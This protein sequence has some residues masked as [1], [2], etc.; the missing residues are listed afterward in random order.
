MR[1]ALYQPDMPPNVGTMLRLG[2]C[3]GVPVEI[4]EPCGFPLSR[5]SLQRSG[6]DYIDQVDLTIHADW[7]MFDAALRARSGRLVLLT[8]R[9]SQRH[10]ACRFHR[11][12]TLLVGQESCGVPDAV[13]QRADLA[14]RIPMVA[15]VRSL[16]VAISAALV[17]GEGL[18]QTG[19]WPA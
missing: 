17:L 1:L 13:H 11:D 2:A 18:R 7:A 14:V 6:L 19:G 4:I 5:R 3:L 8:T 15:G 9:A 12:D 10:D 16:N